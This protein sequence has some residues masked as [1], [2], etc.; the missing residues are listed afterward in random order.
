MR[1]EPVRPEDISSLIAFWDFQGEGSLHAARGHSALLLR[2]MRGPI[3]R[4]PE[5]IFGPSS[6]RIEWGQWLRIPRKDIG[7]LD[8]H[9]RS[10]LSMVAWIRPDS[11][12]PWQFIAGVWNEHDHL[13]QYAL[14]Y[15]GTRQSHSP[16]MN[17]TE[18]RL[19]VHGY[20]SQSG[21]HT[22]GHPACYSY[23]T[24]R[25]ECYPEHWHCIAFT[26][27]LRHIRVYVNGQLDTN[28]DA[29]PFLFDDSIFDG[30]SG[31]ADFTVAQRAMA[32]WH[33]YPDERM[34][35]CEGFSGLL[36]GLAVYGR[37]LDEAE[38][39]VL[40]LCGRMEGV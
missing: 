24:G 27:D 18:C 19:R 6:L 36:G 37:A 34:P 1:R 16:S 4:A 15:N 21:G 20:L 22:P 23:A 32:L 11:D 25:T 7:P 30:G 33:G 13:R 35:A 9:G 28:G 3:R 14:F 29:N 38:L 12:R 31:G 2:E 10:P 40:A 8:L 39:R 17:R 5:G 26:W